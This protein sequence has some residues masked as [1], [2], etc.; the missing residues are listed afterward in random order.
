MSGNV[1]EAGDGIARATGL[2]KV[3]SQELVQFANGVMG[4]AFNLEKRLVGIII[5]GDYS[6]IVEGHDRPRPPAASLLC[7]SA[8]G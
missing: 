1:L 5:M 4:I 3:K 7:R 8:T 6:E 2:A